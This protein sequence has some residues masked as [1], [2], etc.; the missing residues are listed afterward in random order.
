M[1]MKRMQK[2]KKK[3]HLYQ[4]YTE[5]SILLMK[6][7]LLALDLFKWDNLPNGIEGKNIEQFLYEHG[8]VFFY[9]DPDYGFI[10]LPCFTNSGLNIY[11]EPLEVRLTSSNGQVFKTVKAEDGVIIRNN[12]ISMAT[13]YFVRY[14]VDKIYEV[15]NLMNINLNQQRFPFLITADQN[16]ELRMKLIFD[17]F[18][19]DK[20][21]IIAGKEIDNETIQVLQTNAPYLL[22]KLTDYKTEIENELL[23]HLGLNNIR[24]SKRERL[25]V[26]EVNS[27]NDSVDRHCDILFKNRERAVELI[28]EKFGLNIE[29]SKKNDVYN[30]LALSRDGMSIDEELKEDE[31]GESNEME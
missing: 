24:Q 26:D 13:Q 4:Q 28:N 19:G 1:S 21:V 2:N 15:Q 30:S 20:P 31:G 7:M 29:V 16:S 23:S 14:Y 3:Q 11:G 6:Y 22:D 5:S 27:N 8:Q 17:Q 10:C 18:I 12:D 25:L 9:N